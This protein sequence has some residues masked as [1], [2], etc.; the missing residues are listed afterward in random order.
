M[1]SLIYLLFLAFMLF[2]AYFLKVGDQPVNDLLP[3]E[4]YE[5]YLE[6]VNKGA[7]NHILICVVTII[8]ALVPI[9]DSFLDKVR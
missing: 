2:I 4:E 8:A 6:R 9:V 7:R 5:D 3:R 1:M